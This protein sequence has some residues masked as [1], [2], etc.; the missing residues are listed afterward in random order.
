[1]LDI[2]KE[3]CHIGMFSIETCKRVVAM[4]DVLMEEMENAEFE[5]SHKIS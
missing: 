5:K 3:F 1:M 4:I 2:P